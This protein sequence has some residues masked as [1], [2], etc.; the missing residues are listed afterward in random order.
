MTFA[1]GAQAARWGGEGT[2]WSVPDITSPPLSAEGPSSDLFASETRGATGAQG[3]ADRFDH[4]RR[5]LVL[6]LLLPP[7]SPP[8]GDR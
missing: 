8:G 5:N 6:P 7:H 4:C 2:E 1:E 3:L